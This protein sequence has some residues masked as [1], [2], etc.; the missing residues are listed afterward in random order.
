M[1]RTLTITAWWL[2]LALACVAGVAEAR[3]KLVKPGQ[4]PTLDPDEGLLVVAYEV[5]SSMRLM[6][7]RKDGERFPDA[8]I[9]QMHPGDA[10]RL[11]I[12]PAGEYAW[13]HAATFFNIS[14]DLSDDASRRF[15]VKPGI[16]NY[17]G[18]FLMRDTYT[19]TATFMM[20]NRGLRAL[21]WLEKTH[22]KVKRALP[23]AYTGRY[24][25]PFPDWYA[26]LQAST[27]RSGEALAAT[28][29]A[30]APG[31][32]PIDIA[33]LW[34][35]PAI[36]SAD[37]NGRGDLMV[38]LRD[39][40]TAYHLDVM[41]V[42]T[43][44]RTALLSTPRAFE[45][46]A[47][48]GDDVFI[49]ISRTS[50]RQAAFIDV[51]RFRRRDSGSLTF[52]HVK[53]DIVA[54]WAEPLRHEPNY[55]LLGTISPQGDLQVHR[56][57]ISK[58]AALDAFKPEAGTR[59]NHG[60]PGD[61]TWFA[62]GSGNLRLAIG[63]A[64]G[65]EDGQALFH[66]RGGEF[67]E[68]MRF[69]D[70]DSFSPLALTPDGERVI[71]MTDAGRE[72]RDLVV[73][74]PATG[75]VTE[76][77]FSRP[78]VDVS[79]AILDD[80]DGRVIGAVYYALGHPVHHY[81][82][83]AAART[84]ERV[85]QRYPG[86]VVAGLDRA[87]N[88]DMVFSIESVSDP[89]GVYR[90][91]AA[92]DS[93]T[94]VE[95]A[96]PWLQGKVFRDAEVL[97]VKAADGFMLEAYL[98]RPAQPGRRPLVVLAHGGPIG[99]RDVRGFDPEVQLMA[100]MGYAVL[101]VNF[102][103]SDGF[104]TRFRQSGLGNYGAGIEDDIDM[105]LRQVMQDPAIDASRMCA[106]GTSYGGYSALV[107][108]IRWPERFR[109]AVSV[110]G[111]S[112]RFLFFT[113]SD[114][115][116]SAAVRRFMEQ[117]M[118][119][120]DADADTLR[121]RSPLY[122]HADLR[123]PVMLVHGT[124]DLRVDYEHSLRLVRALNASGMPPVLVTLKRGGHGVSDVKEAEAAWGGIAGFLRQHLEGGAAAPAP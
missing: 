14:Y 30:P 75:K 34:R 27:G 1:R 24:H 35:M 15:T 72:Q 59:L 45:T 3:V 93:V 39:G 92:T 118:G 73:F 62:D 101:Q 64:V 60:V 71:A 9:T 37:L 88:G 56:V 117:A 65:T 96:R 53:R 110:A 23:F 81:F 80:V 2:A 10:P 83:P 49:A 119:R 97:Q 41:D 67:R 54:I 36:L 116:Q 77:L 100:A 22:P 69:D 38:V 107:S 103:G 63:D 18:H 48:A 122:R 111:V 8:S 40:D 42:T 51:F 102:R 6:R 46:M 55:L 4:V 86:R 12:V 21:D 52:D 70:A 78:G 84:A 47:W 5:S 74:D 66:G 115:S 114:S 7:F 105:V 32:L 91:D 113:A 120:P 121:D 13:E 57:D 123:T 50:A 87:R 112:D 85:A 43:G 104:G 95:A 25:D 17:P 108:A 11:Y 90:Y 99:V 16:I 19:R 109:C 76:T 31:P 106:V 79:S 20:F 26:G 61:R 89:G 33:S 29:A 44:Q 98:T 28:R 58:Q 82:D 124:D 68:V 94:L